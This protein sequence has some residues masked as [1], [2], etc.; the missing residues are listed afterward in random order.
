MSETITVVLDAMGGDNAPQAPVEGAV[1]A[2]RERKDIKVILTGDQ[3]KIQEELARLGDYPKDQ[4]QIVHTT[5]VIETAEPPV[6]AIR[7]KKDSSIVVGLNLVKQKEA[8]AFVSSGSTGAVLVGG[9]ILVGRIRGVERAPIAVMIPTKKGVSLLIDGGANVDARPSQLVQFAQMGSMYME[10][11]LGIASPKVGIVNNGSEDDKGNALVKDTFPL[12]KET[13]ELNF[14][15]S[16]EPRDIPF[17]VCDVIVCDA[18]VGNAIL[19]MY[20]GTAAALLDIIKGSLTSSLRAKIGALLIKPA[21]KSTLKTFDA[22]QYGGAPLLG[23]KG[24]VVKTHGS[25]KAGEIHNAI[26]QCVQFRQ[27]DIAR[28]IEERLGV[29]KG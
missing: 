19:K 26:L 28:K 10:N 3:T 2:I 17:G 13:R 24:L 12:L 9:T 5:E 20:E 27:H 29:S 21:L 7:N 8:D 4:L 1:R 16:V 11:A 15:G 22:T 25:A 18:F 6:N 23:I 14:I